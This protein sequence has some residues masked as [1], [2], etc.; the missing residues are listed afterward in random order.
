MYLTKLCS[1]LVVVV[2]TA[3]VVAGTVAVVEAAWLRIA[4]VD[5]ILQLSSQA[6]FF[7]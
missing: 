7:C 1:S 6:L 2:G 3:A 4:V 5:A